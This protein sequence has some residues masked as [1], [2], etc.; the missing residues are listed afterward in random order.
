MKGFILSLFA[1]LHLTGTSQE[2]K[3][4]GPFTISGKINGADTGTVYFGYQKKNGYSYDSF[5]L[6]KGFFN[7]K[8]ILPEPSLGYIFHKNEYNRYNDSF[9]VQIALEPGSLIFVASRNDFGNARLIGSESQKLLAELNFKTR[10]DIALS[11]YYQDLSSFLTQKPT[12][13]N[14][15]DVVAQRTSDSLILLSRN[16]TQKFSSRQLQ[17]VKEHPD[18]YLAA[19]FLE[20]NRRFLATDTFKLYFNQLSE[21]TRQSLSG[22]RVKAIINRADSIYNS[23][24]SIDF[25]RQELKGSVLDFASFKKGHYVL[26]DFWAS[27]CVPCREENPHLIELYRKYRKSNLEIIG[28]ASDNK[29]ISAWK[30]AIKKDRTSIWKHVLE[31]PVGSVKSETATALTDLYDVGSLPTQVLI[32]DKGKIIGRYGDKG[33]PFSELDKTLASLFGY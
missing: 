26:I 21:T 23:S 7:F 10:E 22:L 33:K 11:R 5:R 31:K 25:I 14:S 18:S 29:Y 3:D 19:H 1:F 4:G 6:D 15:S 9:Y 2:N 28:V 27:W 12:G 32:D 16:A 24:A 20:N 13:D 8:G 17:F 30:E